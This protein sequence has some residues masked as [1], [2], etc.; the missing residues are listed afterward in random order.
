MGKLSRDG[1]LVWLQ[2]NPFEPGAESTEIYKQTSQFIKETE[3]RI[4]QEAYEEYGS[5]RALCYL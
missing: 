1:R 2:S 4:T 3:N 5:G